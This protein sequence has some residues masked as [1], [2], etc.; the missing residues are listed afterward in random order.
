M[1]GLNNYKIV[2][3]TQ[4]NYRFLR[5]CAFAFNTKCFI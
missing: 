5:D 4:Y 1:F 2:Q 3:E